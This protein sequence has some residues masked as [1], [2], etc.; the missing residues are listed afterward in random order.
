VRIV[1]VITGLDQGG[2]EAMLEKLVL[3][4]RRMNPEIG[5]VVINLGKPGVV[6]NR[7]ARAG[8]AVES[9]GMNLA[10]RSV[11]QLR[12]LAVRL[13]PSPEVTV[14][15]TWLWH[16]DLVGGLCARAAGNRR[17]VWNLRNSMPRHAATK[18]ASR[19]V[20]RVC[21]WLSRWLP[22]RI[23]CNSTAALQAHVAIG[24]Y[25]KKCIVVPNGFDLRR[26]VNS[27][28]ARIEVRGRWRTGPGDALVG[29]VARVDPLKDHATFIRAA[30]I[31][32]ARVPQARFVLIGEGI[33]R[34]PKLPMLL[35]QT[36]LVE[37]F[38]L[39]ERCDDVQT[40]MSALDV[41]CLA[42]WS[43]GFP[44][45][46][47][48][49]M[50]CATPAVATDVGDVRDIL[51]DGRLVAAVGDPGSLATCINYVL[52]LGESGRRAL[53]FKQRCE[54]EARFDIERVWSTYRDLYASI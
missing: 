44:N 5:Q 11:V 48:E 18:P 31:V 53:G 33:T 30:A 37:K 20:A 7:L 14:V 27:A 54:V 34:D 46:L 19:A 12:A 42:S 39:E 28:S 13:R 17:V 49:A 8:V 40:V 25:P 9:L 43:E 3:T 35:A 47:G 45:V 23:I 41:F 38:I 36:N 32:A 4:G 22:A 16:A 15:Q 21:G 2:A 29:M 26:F 10:L 24:Y 52:D 1:H 51:G 6:G 50:A